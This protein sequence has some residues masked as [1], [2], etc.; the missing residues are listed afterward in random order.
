VT[1]FFEPINVS[2]THIYHSALELSP[3]SSIVRRLY[4]HWRHNPFPRVAIGTPD[5]WDQSLALP[6]LHGSN[7]SPALCGP[8]TFQPLHSS[9]TLPAYTWSP[10]GQFIAVH[11][12]EC[13]EIHD[14][15]SLELLSTL[16]PPRPTSQLTGMLAYSPDGCSLAS[17]SSSSLI[18]WDIQTGG[19]A[20]EITCNGTTV[21]SLVWSS[22]GRTVSTMAHDHGLD[23]HTYDIASGSSL[24]PVKLFL[25][26]MP[27]LWAHSMSL[28]AATVRWEGQTFKIDILKVGSVPTKVES[29]PTNVESFHVNLGA[30]NSWGNFFSVKYYQVLAFSSATYYISVTCSDE[31]IIFDIRNSRHLLKQRGNFHSHCF[32]FDGSL[33]IASSDST[34]VHVWKYTS[35]HY[36]PWREFSSF[37][38]L[39]P[40]FSPTLSSILGHFKSTLQVLHLDNP[41][42]VTYPHSH[43]LLATSSSCGTYVVTGH[44]GG[45]TITITNLLS[46]TPSHTIDVGMKVE[47]FALTGNILLVEGPKTIG[48]WQLTE[49]VV[50]TFGH[51]STGHHNRIWTIQFPS[52]LFVVEGQTVTI[53][54]GVKR[55]PL[56][57]YNTGIGE[58]LK[59]TQAP[60][61]NA[62]THTLTGMHHG[63]HYPHYW[64]SVRQKNTW[65]VSETMLQEGWV[66]SPEGKCWL[67]VPV[68]WR[69]SNDIH[70]FHNIRTLWLR[71]IGPGL[72][73]VIIKF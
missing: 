58:L 27:H 52:L 60:L 12:K 61:P 56:Y 65:S 26:S 8:H 37:T 22:D 25:S 23:V 19:V 35:T 36:T 7:T 53:C 55:E 41:S 10:C 59:L 45:S 13:V 39:S 6:Y 72:E 43:R 42:M 16:Q 57:I 24:A 66:K 70:W 44:V 40:C 9:H 50:E 48:A 5:S 46:Q 71:S 38:C 21:G 54:D 20:K 32:S 49:K 33:F 15:L 4:Y 17:L 31:L 47:M 2:A 67:W 34:S 18:I 1:K 64:D 29:I 69:K 73:K 28:R 68:K 63:H 3:F 11:A 62:D 14:P 30:A 51:G